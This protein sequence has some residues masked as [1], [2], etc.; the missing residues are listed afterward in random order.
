MTTSTPGSVA[1][2]HPL[3]LGFALVE[4][5]IAL[6]LGLVLVAAMGQLYSG[7]RRAYL[8]GDS[9]TRLNESGRFAVDFL[10][11]DLRMA[12]YLS[13]GGSF[14]RIGNSL[15]GSNDWRYVTGG[16]E[17]FEGGV[18]SLPTQFTGQVRADTDVLVVR[19]APIDLERTLIADD[20]SN[21]TMEL[22]VDHGFKAG[23]VLVVSD[24]SCT[25]TALLQVTDVLKQTDDDDIDGIKHV[26]GTQSSP[27]N[28]TN[29]LFGSFDCSSAGSSEAGQFKPGSV[30][31]RFAVHAYYVTATDPPT[32]ARLRLC[33]DGNGSS[34]TCI[35]ELVRDVESLQVLYGRDIF[36]D[37]GHSV[38]DY[39][40]A[41]QVTDWVDVVSVRFSLLI[42]SPDS[43][44]RTMPVSLTFD[45][46][47]RTVTAPNDR[48]LRRQFGSVVALRNNLP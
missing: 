41:D 45:L 12:G 25:Q 23:E 4:L 22:G 11:N 6:A 40:T 30:V 24:P 9:L 7:G 27:G 32:L 1:A 5:M 13:C 48:H 39:V 37:G 34:A 38:D 21:A 43:N 46:L 16:I 8:V 18:D 2:H 35:D 19:R 47:G 28:C 3:Q 26:S 44:V 29:N 20:V 31:S 10:S 17:G 36:K 15:N 42:R 33:H 14:A